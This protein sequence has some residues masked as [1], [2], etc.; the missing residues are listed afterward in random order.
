MFTNLINAS[1]QMHPELLGKD[2][3]LV[4]SLGPI[5]NCSAKA[6]YHRKSKNPAPVYPDPPSCLPNNREWSEWKTHTHTRIWFNIQN[7][8]SNLHTIMNI[9]DKYL[10]KKRACTC[11]LIARTNTHLKVQVAQPVVEIRGDVGFNFFKLVQLWVWLPPEQ[12]GFEPGSMTHK[13]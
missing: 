3:V 6:F 2:V 7:H 10:Q 8:N 9:R 4:C 12:R 13:R 1:A 5:S 11:L